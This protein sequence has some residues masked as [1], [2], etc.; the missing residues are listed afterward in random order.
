MLHITAAAADVGNPRVHAAGATSSAV[1][2][3]STASVAA[4]YYRDSKAT[5]DA[6]WH[7]YCRMDPVA[8]KSNMQV[9]G[10]MRDG[11]YLLPL[12]GNL[13]YLLEYVAADIEGLARDFHAENS[14][15]ANV[16]QKIFKVLKDGRAGF[17][18]LQVYNGDCITDNVKIIHIHPQILT[19]GDVRKIK[20]E[21]EGMLPLR[22]DGPIECPIHEM[23][24]VGE[25]D[26]FIVAA[27]NLVGHAQF[28]RKNMHQYSR[29]DTDFPIS[30]MQSALSCGKSPYAGQV[31]KVFFGSYKVFLKKEGMFL[32]VTKLHLKGGQI[33]WHA[34][35]IDAYRDIFYFGLGED[36]FQ[37]TFLIEKPDRRDEGSAEENL[38][39]HFPDLERIEV[40]HVI[41]MQLKVSKL[42]HAPY[43]AY[44]LL[45]SDDKC[46]SAPPAAKKLKITAMVSK[47]R[48]QEL[49]AQA[50]QNTPHIVEAGAVKK[51]RGRPKGSKNRQ[52]IERKKTYD[53]RKQTV[54]EMN[55]EDDLYYE[56]TRFRGEFK[57]FADVGAHR[58]KQAALRVERKQAIRAD[59]LFARRVRGYDYREKY[60]E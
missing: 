14:A 45:G 55:A 49:N 6:R 13:L 27:N 53:K 52:P 59:T 50:G 3:E 15:M 17:M 26:C 25:H 42:Q 28:S 8:C 47:E 30:Q 51:K 43:I 24:Y 37:K 44:N 5:L 4:Q 39:E 57:S 9:V 19:A 41:K 35:G 7:N 36:G 48:Q 38:L 12:P 31:Q 10:C 22:R 1:D 20:D 29:C 60:I 58:M 18:R 33:Q 21:Q 40:I 54:A 56:R 23:A 16:V 32:V 11:E 2:G 46:E 34:I